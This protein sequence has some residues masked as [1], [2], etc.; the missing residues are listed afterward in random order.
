M[1]AVQKA[2]IAKRI[3]KLADGSIDFAASDMAWDRNSDRR[4]QPH[5]R[6]PAAA[7][8]AGAE[9][10]AE[11]DDGDFGEA[12]RQREWE[13]VKRERLARRKSEGELLEASE[14]EKTWG[15]ILSRIKSTLLLLPDEV[16]VKVASISDVRVCRSTVDREVRDAL[17]LLSECEYDAA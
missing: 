2:I 6:R 17:A 14:V 15:T 7:A 3:A 10:L 5:V 8:Q 11:T 1:R 9:P 16:A 13:R 4:K 12:Q